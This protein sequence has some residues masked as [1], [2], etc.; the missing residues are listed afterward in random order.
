MQIVCSSSG[1]HK[2]A[3]RNFI[4]RRVIGWAR[5]LFFF[6]QLL[7]LLSHYNRLVE[8]FLD[9]STYNWYSYALNDRQFLNWKYRYTRVTF[10]AILLNF[11]AFKSKPHSTPKV[12]CLTQILLEFFKSR[13]KTGSDIDSERKRKLLVLMGVYPMW[14]DRTVADLRSNCENEIVS[15]HYDNVQFWKTNWVF[16]SLSKLRDERMLATLNS[17]PKFV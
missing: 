6:Q 7:S 3:S 2:Q 5:S 11:W 4:S 1:I 17:P 16:F 10:G 12:F 8:C 9:G 14:T 13:P 15:S